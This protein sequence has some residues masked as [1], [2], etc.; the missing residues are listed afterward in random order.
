VFEGNSAAR[1]GALFVGQDWSLPAEQRTCEAL[2]LANTTFA[3]NSALV[4]GGGVMWQARVPFCASLCDAARNCS[5]DD[6]RAA[7]SFASDESFAVDRIAVADAF[8]AAAEARPGQRVTLAFEVQTFRHELAPVSVAEDNAPILFSLTLSYANASDP[9]AVKGVPLSGALNC[10]GCSGVAV[11]DGVARFSNISFFLHPGAYV[12]HVNTS[13]PGIGQL[14]SSL[15]VGGC[16]DRFYLSDEGGRLHCERVVPISTLSLAETARHGF[17]ASAAVFG[18]L[19]LGATPVVEHAQ[20]AFCAAVLLG[21]LLGLLVTG[22]SSEYPPSEV[23]CALAPWLQ[24]AALA[25]IGGALLAKLRL[26]VRNNLD[27][28]YHMESTDLRLRKFLG[29]PLLVSA[30]YLALWTAAG[31]AR[32]HAFLTLYDKGTDNAFMTQFILCRSPSPGWPATLLVLQA[33]VVLYG[34]LL[35]LRTSHIRTHYNER[36]FVSWVMYA[37]L[38]VLVLFVALFVGN[39]TSPERLYVVSTLPILAISV[40][41][42]LAIFAPKVARVLSG[43]MTDAAAP[44]AADTN[45]LETEALTI[46][47]LNIAAVGGRRGAGA[48]AGSGGGGGG[49]AESESMDD[50]RRDTRYS[51]GTPSDG[52]SEA[53][54]DE[55]LSGGGDDAA[56]AG[57]AAAPHELAL[58]EAGASE[59]ANVQQLS[60]DI[61]H[62]QAQNRSLQADMDAEEELP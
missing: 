62:L 36:T 8:S 39:S 45:E 19:S 50:L 37:L 6:N 5:Y 20:G 27:V 52:H 29:I 3:R 21:V 30:L 61:A 44:P 18:S 60:R 58:P 22:Y 14:E 48:G 51:V 25:L 15:A 32:P 24:N 28:R 35:A 31:R 49:A 47:K 10:S 41:A 57:A 11:V 2:V 16:A 53:D 7:G 38:I 59:S 46:P 13:L 4:A 34:V 1:G 23:Q 17:L 9:L 56:D 43:N 26:V 42:L 55:V 40:G 54:E 33:A 12:I